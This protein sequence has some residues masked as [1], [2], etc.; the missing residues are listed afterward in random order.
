M[1]D[2][3]GKALQSIRREPRMQAG[4]LEIGMADGEVIAAVLAGDLQRY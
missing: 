2:P 4:T 1:A 3:P